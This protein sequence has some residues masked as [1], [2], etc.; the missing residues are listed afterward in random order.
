[1]AKPKLKFNVH[2]YN[3]RI[4]AGISRV[5]LAAAAGISPRTLGEIEEGRAGH[6][7]PL[8]DAAII[9]LPALAGHPQPAPTP[10]LTPTIDPKVAAYLDHIEELMAIKRRLRGGAA[11]LALVKSFGEIMIRRDYGQADLDFL[12]G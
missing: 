12:F 5:T 8:Y 6:T 4:A 7:K 3:L 2:L 10:I 1:M 11:Q 9:M